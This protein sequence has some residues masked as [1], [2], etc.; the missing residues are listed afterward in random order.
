MSTATAEDTSKSG[1]YGDLAKAIALY[2]ASKK[3]T[4]SGDTPNFYQVPLTPE[5]QRVEDEKWRVY[6]DGGSDTMKT[7]QGLGKQFLSG[8]QSGPSNFQFMSPEL[9]GQQFAGGYKL[10]TF[11][12]SK[13]PMGGPPSPTKPSAIDD[14]EKRGAKTILTGS[15][16]Q[17]V[18]PPVGD[19]PDYGETIGDYLYRKPG[20]LTPGDP[21]LEKYFPN[22]D[23]PTIP[24]MSYSDGNAFTQ[25][26]SDWWATYQAEHPDWKDA[27]ADAL[28]AVLTGVF[29]PLGAVA[30]GVI[31]YI[32]RKA[33]PPTTPPPTTPPPTGRP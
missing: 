29:G 30:G 6:K 11:D 31:K 28:K 22:N 2:F 23:G 17:D 33:L 20:A 4:G 7:V 19:G 14:R 5:Q 21:D 27:G 16:R 24:G 18:G 26:V 32:I 25:K 9:K 3:G 15:P 1:F 10:P 12:F 13:L 8:L